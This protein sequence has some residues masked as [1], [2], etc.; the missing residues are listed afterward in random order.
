MEAVAQARFVRMSCR[1]LRLIADEL[2]GKPV[3]L[4]FSDLALLKNTKK[5]AEIFEKVLKS[6]VANFQD[7]DQD[8]SVATESLN[9]KEI[10][11]DGGP[12]IKRIRARA[13]GR[14]FRIIK[15][16]SHV[17]VVIGEN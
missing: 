15:K 8:A 4:A 1:K 9:I 14:A 3:D 6:A 7:K 2:R 5:G 11:V 12:Q 17:T 10:T 13:Q 16:T